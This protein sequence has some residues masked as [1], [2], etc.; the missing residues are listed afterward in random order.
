LSRLNDC[1]D[2]P[3][4][5]NLRATPSIFFKINDIYINLMSLW[6]LINFQRTSILILIVYFYNIFIVIKTLWLL[7]AG[8]D[9]RG[10]IK[11]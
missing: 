6:W 9:A 10:F 4:A 5:E 1:I 7:V 8:Y 11:L 2:E 3:T